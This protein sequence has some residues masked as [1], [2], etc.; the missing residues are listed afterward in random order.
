MNISTEEYLV[1][2]WFNKGHIE[3]FM[4]RK[5]TDQ[6]FKEIL[7]YYDDSGIC[8]HISQDIREWIGDNREEID[9]LI[10]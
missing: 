9:E 6:Q 5:L 10:E 7:E 1:P 3:S 2:N 8:D 4:K